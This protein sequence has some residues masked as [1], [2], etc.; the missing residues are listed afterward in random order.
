V[1]NS[2]KMVRDF[3]H[4]DDVAEGA[5]HSSTTYRVFNIRTPAPIPLMGVT[6]VI[7]QDE[8]RSNSA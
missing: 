5:A 8:D 2:R 1:F 4:I 3:T 6:E 7:K